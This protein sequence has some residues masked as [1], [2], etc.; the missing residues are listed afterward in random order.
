MEIFQIQNGFSLCNFNYNNLYLNWESDGES[1]FAVKAIETFLISLSHP[2][3]CFPSNLSPFLLSSTIVADSQIEIPIKT[4]LMIP[5]L[6]L[7]FYTVGLP[8]RNTEFE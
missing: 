8:E 3:V 1:G 2:K 5:I 7:C 4:F 6:V